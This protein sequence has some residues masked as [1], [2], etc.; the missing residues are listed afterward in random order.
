MHFA[1][2]AAWQAKQV[3]SW[4]DTKL[5]DEKEA[6]AIKLFEGNA[7]MAEAAAKVAKAALEEFDGA[8]GRGGARSLRGLGD[9]PAPGSDFPALVSGIPR[10]RNPPT[11][12]ADSGFSRMTPGRCAA[13]RA[14]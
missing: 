2:T 7:A 6:S 8:T 12:A 4:S 11:H 14:M 3:S 5:D 9:S 1:E 10:H 13:I